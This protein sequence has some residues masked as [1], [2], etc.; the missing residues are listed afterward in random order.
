MSFLQNCLLWLPKQTNLCL[1]LGATKGYQ[2]NEDEEKEKELH[3]KL[4]SAIK[5]FAQDQP[6]I[7]YIDIDDCVQDAS[8]FEGGLN[9]FSTRVYY[10]IAQAMIRVIREVTGKQVESYSSGMV[11]FDEWVLTVRK[12]IKKVIHPKGKLYGRLKGFYDR[13]YKHRK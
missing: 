8:D 7:R 11:W 6:R 1:I 13:V 5:S 4:N 12:T 9:H 10:E 2:G 3:R